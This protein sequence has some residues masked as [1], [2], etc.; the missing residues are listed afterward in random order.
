[1]VCFNCNRNVNKYHNISGHQYCDK[2]K[3]KFSICESCQN[4]TNDYCTIS[5]NTYCYQCADK[6]QLI[7]CPMTTCFE[8]ISINGYND[9]VDM[10][11]NTCSWCNCVVCDYCIIR[12][13]ND[14]KCRE[15]ISQ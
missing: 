6:Y 15:C 9:T 8:I 13:Q 10:D 1:M 11:K 4:L 14:Q 7:K 12:Y 3:N 2:C 5:N